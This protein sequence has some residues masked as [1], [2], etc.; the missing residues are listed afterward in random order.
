MMTVQQWG[1]HGIITAMMLTSPADI[2]DGLANTYL[3]GEKYLQPE[4]YLIG[5]DLGDNECAYIGDNEDITRYTGPGDVPLR[6]RHGY[7]DCIN[8]GSAHI[9]GFNMC[10][11]DGSTRPIS[12]TINTL[13]HQYLG[14]R[15]DGIAQVTVNGLSI[16][17]APPP[18]N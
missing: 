1:A 2:T 9:N 3:A 11:C 5:T 7:N 6:D 15:S 4:L 13:V 12:Y 10:F 18:M 14:N 8:F 17:V 16:P